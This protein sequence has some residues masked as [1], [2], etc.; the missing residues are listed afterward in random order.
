MI[1]A[2]NLEERER[3][4]GHYWWF[5]PHNPKLRSY[6]YVSAPDNKTIISI[7]E[8]LLKEVNEF[9]EKFFKPLTVFGSDKP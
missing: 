5:V 6:S 4:D 2:L 7:I 9:S 1:A 8:S 3:R